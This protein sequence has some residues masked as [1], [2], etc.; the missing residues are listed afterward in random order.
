MKKTLHLFLTC[1]SLLALSIPTFAQTTITL[2]DLAGSVTIG[3]K[4][5]NSVDSAATVDMG[6]VGGPNAWDFSSVENQYTLALDFVDPADTPFADTFMTATIASYSKFVIDSTSTSEVWGFNFVSDGSGG[7]PE[8]VYELGS[9]SRTVFDGQEVITVSRS[10]TPDRFYG[11]P[12]QFED[13]WVTTDTTVTTTFFEGASLGSS[14]EE[15]VTRLVDAWGTMTLPDN[16]TVDALRIKETSVRN[17]TSIPGFPPTMITTVTY[18]FIGKNGNVIAAGND[19]GTAM[20][21]GTLTGYVSWSQIGDGGTSGT[22]VEDAFTLDDSFI[23][24]QNFPNP[25]HS[26][27]TIAF[28][29]EEAGQVSLQIYDML[30]REMTTVTDRFVQPGVHSVPVS[31]GTLPGGVYLYKLVTP[32][33]VQVRTMTVI[34]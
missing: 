31:V 33:G 8:G 2:D 4:F 6:N 16:T 21:S 18:V 27:S 14:S 9:A 7:V 29:A 23:L 12:L 19:E 10:S 17:I 5:V 22:S 28:T 30:G 34:Q 15:T 1:L 24:H 3:G 13:E 26:E 11:T 25:F 20:D 32:K